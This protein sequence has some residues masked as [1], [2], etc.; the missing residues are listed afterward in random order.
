MGFAELAVE[1]QR[2]IIILII[3]VVASVFL[4]VTMKKGWVKT[5]Q[6]S[7]KEGLSI[8]SNSSDTLNKLNAHSLSQDISDIDKALR[9]KCLKLVYELQPKIQLGLVNS[10]ICDMARNGLSWAFYVPLMLSIEENNFRG[11]FAKLHVD[12]HLVHIVEEIH[13]KYELYL[14]QN[15]YGCEKNNVPPF[16]EV[17]EWVIKLLREHWIKT[18]TDAICQACLKKI[19]KYEFYLIRFATT[20][21]KYNIAVCEACI[22][23]NK[24][25][26][27]EVRGL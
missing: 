14:L 11:K 2:L 22:E 8:N 4:V 25:Y 9:I 24:K 15:K 19:E 20:G 13:T 21:D 5:F 16:I 10:T 17:E 6:A 18:V 1:I 23:K 7:F 3:T 27:Q 12:A 26:V